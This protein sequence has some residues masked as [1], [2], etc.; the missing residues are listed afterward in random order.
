MHQI[1]LPLKLQL[2]STDSSGSIDN[3]LILSSLFLSPSIDSASDTPLNRL[4]FGFLIRDN[5]ALDHI[6]LYWQSYAVVVWTKLC[7]AKLLAWIPRFPVVCSALLF[8]LK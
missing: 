3:I 2:Q 4:Y 1:L 5:F 7:S 6:S 8:F